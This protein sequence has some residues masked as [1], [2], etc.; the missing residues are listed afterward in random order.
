MSENITYTNASFIER[1]KA[2]LIDIFMIYMPILY[3]ITY[4]FLGNKESFLNSDIAPLIAISLYAII[5]SFLVFKYSQ[6]PGKKAYEIYILNAD[7][8]KL[9]FLQAFLRFVLFLFSATILFGILLPIIR[10]DN[11]SMHDMILHT[12][13]VKEI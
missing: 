5:S 13:V 9:S 4:L 10:K 2:T 11:K 1:T 3:I 12:K 6:T 8:T 7:N